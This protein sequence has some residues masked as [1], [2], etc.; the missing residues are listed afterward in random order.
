MKAVNSQATPIHG[1]AKSVPLKMGAWVGRINL[2]AVPLDDFRVILG[3]DFLRQTKAVPMPFVDSLGMFGECPC[4]VPVSTRKDEGKMISALQLKKGLRKGELTYLATLRIEPGD[5]DHSTV[6][7]QVLQVLEEFKDVM[8]KELPKALPP[9]RPIDHQ[10]ELVPGAT[11][12]ARGPY[13]M[14]PPERVTQTARCSTG[15]RLYQTF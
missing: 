6:P 2:L 14:S 3:M 9:R 4:F 13:R 7:H 8:P 11:P 15:V 12:P 5:Q 10:I 1:L